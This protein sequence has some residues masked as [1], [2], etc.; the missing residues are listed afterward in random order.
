MHHPTASSDSE[1]D[2]QTRLANLMLKTRAKN[3][4][5]VVAK[6]SSQS[7]VAGPR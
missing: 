6:K 4:S 3:M 1:G 5:D 2:K 7:E